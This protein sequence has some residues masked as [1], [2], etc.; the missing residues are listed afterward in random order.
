MDR[1]DPRPYQILVL[2]SLTAWGV[3]AARLPDLSDQLAVTALTACLSQHLLSRRYGL[4]RT[5]LRS[6]IITSLG[7]TLL[8][9]TDALWVAAL[10]ALIAIGSKFVLRVHGK[11]VFNPGM[12]G[13]VAVTLGTEHAWISPGQWGTDL[14]LSFTLA[15]AGL[16]VVFR[17]ERTDVTVAFLLAW[18][19][20]LFGRAAWLGDPWAIPLHQLGAGSTVLFAFFM[21][22][23]PK[24][25]PDARPARIAWACAVAALAGWL[26]LRLW[27]DAGPIWALALLSPAVPLLDRLLPAERYTWARR[28]RATAPS[29]SNQNPP[30]LDPGLAAQPPQAPSTSQVSSNSPSQSLSIWSPQI[31]VAVGPTSGSSS[32]QSSAQ[33]VAPSPS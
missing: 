25:T 24:T 17:S 5:D 23:D 20:V 21:I 6:A 9:R 31:S 19:A 29:S 4:D 33:N 15:S 18:T 27:W 11:H 26:Q 14:G 3:Y 22:S 7:L 1:S 13:I 8:L 12:L 2:G 10:A 30:A 32:S 28:R 16:A